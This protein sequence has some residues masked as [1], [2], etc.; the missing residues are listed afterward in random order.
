MNLLKYLLLLLLFC[1]CEVRRIMLLQSLQ[2]Q[3]AFL[4]EK[5]SPVFWL[6]FL[7]PPLR[8]LTPTH[9]FLFFFFPPLPPHSFLFLDF[10]PYL[11]MLRGDYWLC[12]GI[13]SGGGQEA[14]QGT[15]N[16]IQVRHMQ[17]TCPTYC[18]LDPSCTLISDAQFLLHT[19]C[20][21]LELQHS[22]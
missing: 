13:T 18:T 21:G 9:S 5:R 12:S 1:C 19:V 20:L 3:Q 11:E 10:G 2:D 4:K 16:W 15:G 17:S 8:T 6:M 7:Y 14:I 22:G